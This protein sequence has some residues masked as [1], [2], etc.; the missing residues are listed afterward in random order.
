MNLFPFFRESKAA[1]GVRST[2]LDRFLL[3]PPG[4]ARLCAGNPFR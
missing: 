2:K 4:F 3:L 1:P